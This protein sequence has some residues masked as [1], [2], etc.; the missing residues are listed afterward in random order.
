MKIKGLSEHFRA[1]MD[2]AKHGWYT[3]WLGW[4]RIR[5]L[6]LKYRTSPQYSE[7]TFS[8]ATSDTDTT[9]DQ[10][11]PVREKRG[12]PGGLW[13][14]LPRLWQDDLSAPGPAADECLSRVRV[15]HVSQRPRP[16]YWRT[17]RWNL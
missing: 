5:C 2:G 17:G 6:F 15:S 14:G 12:V 3:D 4:Y 10:A 1:G 9:G 11:K 8:M 7:S 13:F 16:H